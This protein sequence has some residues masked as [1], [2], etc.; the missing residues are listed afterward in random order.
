MDNGAEMSEARPLNGLGEV[1]LKRSVAVSIT[2]LLTLAGMSARSA[3][4]AFPA[5]IADTIQELATAALNEF[6][7]VSIHRQGTE[8]R[9]EVNATVMNHPTYNAA[10]V[11]DGTHQVTTPNVDGFVLRFEYREHANSVRR[12]VTEDGRYIVKYATK[13]IL[14]RETTPA[15]S[16][17]EVQ[18]LFIEVHYGTSLAPEWTERINATL[19]ALQSLDVKP[20]RD[21]P[22]P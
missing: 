6:P 18:A 21:R 16:P 12:T 10:G 1:H 20:R 11:K 17:A 9:I 7:S 19:K 5:G 8:I 13:I 2:I 4:P 22:K 14:A 15:G 3:E